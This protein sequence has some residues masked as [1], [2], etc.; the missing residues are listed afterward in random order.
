MI[1]PQY[2]MMH[3]NFQLE[4]LFYHSYEDNYFHLLEELADQHSALTLHPVKQAW[5][6][7]ALH[8]RY[9]TGLISNMT[10]VSQTRLAHECLTP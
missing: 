9:T 5:L 2:V 1:T 4:Q 3:V 7:N 10:W 6:M 8:Q